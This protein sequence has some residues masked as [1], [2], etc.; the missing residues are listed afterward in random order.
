[1]WMAGIAIYVVACVA[2]YIWIVTRKDESEDPISQ[3]RWVLEPIDYDDRR[4]A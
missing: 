3:E 2:F 1:M 4:A